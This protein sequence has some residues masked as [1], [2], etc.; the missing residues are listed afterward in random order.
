MPQME[1][2]VS[3]RPCRGSDSPR[4]KG[5]G[6]SSAGRPGKVEGRK[7]GDVDTAPRG[8]VSLRPCAGY[9]NR[10]GQESNARPSGTQQTLPPSSRWLEAGLT[11]PRP[12]TQPTVR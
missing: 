10:L 6:T 1:Y 11:H 3:S 5:E 4:S 12:V 9:R 8:N 7:S 2:V